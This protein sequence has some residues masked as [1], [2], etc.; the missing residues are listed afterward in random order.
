MPLEGSALYEHLE[1]TPEATEDFQGQDGTITG[2]RAQRTD[3]GAERVDAPA[4]ARGSLVVEFKPEALLPGEL[5][6]VSPVPSPDQITKRSDSEL[7]GH[8]GHS[9]TAG[10]M[11][12]VSVEPPWRQPEVI[13]VSTPGEFIADSLFVLCHMAIGKC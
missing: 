4:L 7:L 3:L 12:G 1:G 6:R 10:V 11:V 2:M 5:L 13:L 8:L 9:P